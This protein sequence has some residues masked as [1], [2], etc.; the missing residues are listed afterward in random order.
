MCIRD[1]PISWKPGYA[2]TVVL[3]AEGYPQNP[4]KG[5]VIT[6]AEGALH[7]GTAV[8]DGQL[9]SAGG[10]VLSVV[11]LGESLEEARTAAYEQISRI[12]LRG[13]HY[14]RDIGLKAAEG[15]LSVQ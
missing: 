14:R 3:A 10:R 15:K 7:A 12:E 6:G 8:K 5:D 2:V 1:R 13:S 9:V 11:G 4:V